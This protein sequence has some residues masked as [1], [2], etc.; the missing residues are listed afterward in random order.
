M[1]I[2]IIVVKD[3]RVSRF[4]LEDLN[5]KFDYLNESGHC[6][7]FC[8]DF[9]QFKSV[10][11]FFQFIIEKIKLTSSIYLLTLPFTIFIKLFIEKI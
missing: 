7:R 6:L 1:I 8:L 9:S 10:L 11:Q 4:H 2:G 5:L 3:S